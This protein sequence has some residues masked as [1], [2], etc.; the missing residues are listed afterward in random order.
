LDR[1]VAATLLGRELGL[2]VHAGHGLTYENVGPVA[3]IA[4]CEELNIG[5]SVVSRSLFVGI[6]TA[7][8]EM[9][10]LIQGARLDVTGG[11]A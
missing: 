11:R 9:K 3:A 1:L 10:S 7:V 4:D 6:E 8:R 2:A 5:H